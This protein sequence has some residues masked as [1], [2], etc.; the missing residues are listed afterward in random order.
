[1][2]PESYRVDFTAYRVDLVQ[3]GLDRM[4]GQFVPSCMLRQFVAVFLRQCQE[5]YD[6]ALDVLELRTLYSAGDENLDALGRIVG[7]SRTAYRYDEKS[8][9]Y[10]DRDGQGADQIAVW[11]VNAPLGVLVTIMDNEYRASILARILSNHTLTASVP[12]LAKIARALTGYDISF[13][14]T[15][16]MQVRILVPN[17]I[18]QTALALFTNS[19]TSALADNKY[20]MPYPATLSISE[21]LVF[22]EQ[23]FAAD[24]PYPR[25]TDVAPV[26]VGAV[27]TP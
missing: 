19:V 14:K 25:V 10:S 4:L 11:C 23:Y 16:P 15:G 20:S 17:N 21:V 7:E 1:M 2:I 12:E 5:L 3:E 8:W 13:E 9:M 18:S 26:S 27:T 6:A 22:A 24:R